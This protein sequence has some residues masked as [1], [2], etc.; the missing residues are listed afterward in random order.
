MKTD[1]W[2][3]SPFAQR[4][5]QGVIYLHCPLERRDRKEYRLAPPYLRLPQGSVFGCLP[6]RARR[7]GIL[8]NQNATSRDGEGRPS[9]WPLPRGHLS[10]HPPLDRRAFGEPC[11]RRIIRYGNR[12]IV[13]PIEDGWEPTQ[14]AACHSCL[15]AVR[16]IGR[17]ARTQQTCTTF[18]ISTTTSLS[19]HRV[20][21]RPGL[22]RGRYG[23]IWT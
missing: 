18:P 8:G 22:H 16:Q 14:G 7:R 9:T 1:G 17:G 20:L 6:R 10:R 19:F 15:R 3:V 11:V 21:G 5:N 4:P 23:D 13:V 2:S 12:A